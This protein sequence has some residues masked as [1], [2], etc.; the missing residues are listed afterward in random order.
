MKEI[1]KKGLLASI[2]LAAYTKDYLENVTKELRKKG[3]TEAEGKRV[4]D[5]LVKEGKKTKDQI[6]NIAEEKINIILKDIE[7]NTTNKSKSAQK[8]RKKKK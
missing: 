7:K 6:L 3:Y 1:L 2:G 5:A 4:V 8:K